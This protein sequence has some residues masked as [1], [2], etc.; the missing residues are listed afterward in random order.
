M[1]LVVLVG[2]RRKAFQ[3]AR[4]LGLD[5]IR[6]SSR[7]SF[8]QACAKI[9]TARRGRKLK[10]VLATT[11]SAQWTA[12]RLRTRFRV[13]GLTDKTVLPFHDKRAMKRKARQLGIPTAAFQ[14]F[15]RRSPRHSRKRIATRLARRWGFPMVVKSPRLSGSRE[16]IIAH[17][18]RTL[19]RALDRNRHPDRIV[20][21]WLHGTEMSC[22]L[23]LQRGRVIFENLTAYIAHH[24]INL[25][26]APLPKPVAVLTK[27]FARNVARGFGVRDGIIH[28]ELFWTARGP[29][30]GELTQ[31]PPGGYLMDLIRYCYRVDAWKLWICSELGIPM[32]RKLPKARGSALAWIIHPGAGRIRSV[33]GVSQIRKHPALRSWKSQPTRNFTIGLRKGSGEEW[34]HALFS[35]HDRRALVTDVLKLR[36]G[37]KFTL[38]P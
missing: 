33:T 10:A 29:F 35:A 13:R 31:R 28:L 9:E 24:A 5:V 19:H 6:I 30:L 21:A 36:A 27:A 37:L 3:A 22:E 2:R 7:L 25:M 20:E 15:D 18:L 8:E 1:A 4:A 17:D 23:V 26:P 11:E 32:P 12:A 34:G 38:S 16:Q 14:I